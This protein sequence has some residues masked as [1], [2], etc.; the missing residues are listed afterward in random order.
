[1]RVRANCLRQA[2]LFGG[3]DG[4]YV[5]LDEVRHG[6]QRLPFRPSREIVQGEQ[7]AGLFQPRHAATTSSSIETRFQYFEDDAVFGEEVA[8]AADQEFARAVDETRGVPRQPLEAEKK[9][10]VRGRGGGH[11][12]LLRGEIAFSGPERNSNS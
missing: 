6:D 10:A 4:E 2:K 11:V 5:H 8:I 12:G 9:E 3:D 1:M 7:I